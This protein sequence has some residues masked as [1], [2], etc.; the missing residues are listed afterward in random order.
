MGSL[1]VRLIDRNRYAKRYPLI[2]APK[3]YVYQG[4]EY[5]ALEVG[6]IYFDDSDT[7]S[8]QFEAQFTDANY[9]LAIAARDGGDSGGA[10]V[11]VY[12]S[13][14][15]TSSVT[16]QASGNFTGWVDVFAIRV[17]T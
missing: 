5:M 14:R 7:G 4:E 15:S 12:I 13:S 8:L 11:N 10:N 2:R 17:G 3:R 16:V 9:T 6:S 1:R